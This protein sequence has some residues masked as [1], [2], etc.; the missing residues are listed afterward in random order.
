MIEMIRKD[1]IPAVT[2]YMNEISETLMRKQKINDMGGNISY[3]ME[4]ELLERLSNLSDLL[5]TQCDGLEESL[6]N[7]EKSTT[8]EERAEYYKSTVHVAMHEARVTADHLET[9][10]AKKYWP[11][12]TYSDLLY[13]VV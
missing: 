6:D 2:T 11:F 13:S 5:F 7:A 10:T 4:Q 8:Y 1:I 9:I 3:N 12:P